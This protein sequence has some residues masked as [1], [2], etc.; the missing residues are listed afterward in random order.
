MFKII[1][2]AKERE[3]LLEAHHNLSFQITKNL[4][5]DLILLNNQVG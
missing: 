5:F 2:L 3:Q 1:S 4:I